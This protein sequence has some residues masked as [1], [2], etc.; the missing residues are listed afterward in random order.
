TGLLPFVSGLIWKLLQKQWFIQSS[1][2]FRE[3]YTDKSM[4]ENPENIQH[5]LSPFV[6]SKQKTIGAFKY[7]KGIDWKVIDD[8]KTTHKNIKANVL[9]LW[10][11]DDK[12][13][14]IRFASE[15]KNQFTNAQFYTIKNASLLPHEEKP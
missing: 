3:A 2:G 9:L 12:T 1:M 8:F 10:G 15:M 11:E 6:H 5:Y 4:L 14:P 7:L 13:F